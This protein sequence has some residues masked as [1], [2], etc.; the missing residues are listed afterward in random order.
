MEYGR[1]A[2]ATEADKSDLPPAAFQVDAACSS[3][4]KIIGPEE[5]STA[6]QFDFLLQALF[7]EC[8]HLG[9]MVSLQF[10][11]PIFDAAA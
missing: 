8:L 7:E 6:R 5:E 3:A 4:Q 1:D 2:A 9:A 11:N 10:N